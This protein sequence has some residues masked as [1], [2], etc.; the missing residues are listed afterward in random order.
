[1]FVVMMKPVP[2]SLDRMSDMILRRLW[3][4]IDVRIADS[5]SWLLAR[6]SQKALKTIDSR[7]VKTAVPSVVWNIPRSRSHTSWTTISTASGNGVP[8]V[9]QQCVIPA[10]LTPIALLTMPTLRPI[11]T[12]L[13][14]KEKSRASLRQTTTARL[15]KLSA[16]SDLRARHAPKLTSPANARGSYIVNHLLIDRRARVS[17]WDYRNRAGRE[18]PRG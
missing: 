14:A 12:G 8:H 9:G 2:Y 4:R 3:D 11:P 18:S 1:M 7:E 10:V 16:G 17:E 5:S 6:R 15:P 13:D